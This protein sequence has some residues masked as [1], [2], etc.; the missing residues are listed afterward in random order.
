[1]EERKIVFATNNMH[2]LEEVR[3]MFGP[4]LTVF[5]LKEIGCEED[6]PETGTSFRENAS[7]KSHYIYQR[8]GMD[9][10]ADDS[11]L[12]V[13]ALH[14]APGIFSARY[15]GKNSSSAANIEKLLHD[16]KDKQRREAHFR[17]VISLIIGGNEHFFEGIIPGSIRYSPSGTGGFGYDPIFQPEGYDVTFAE[18]TA[19]EKNRIS[20]RAVAIQ[21]LTAFLT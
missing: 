8:Y 5:S 14:G 12:V 2:K 15:A 3:Q 6:V 18:M 16:L 13:T 21:K 11:G 9:C 1:M 10:F 20:H 4:G 19:D 7:I 17:T